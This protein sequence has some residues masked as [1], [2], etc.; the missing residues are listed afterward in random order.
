MTEMNRLLTSAAVFLCLATSATAQRQ[1]TVPTYEDRKEIDLNDFIEIKNQYSWHGAQ[2]MAIHDGYLFALYHLGDCVV[3]DLKNGKFIN[4]YIIAGA[5]KT[6]CN[7]ASFGVEYADSTSRFPLLYVSECG[8]PMR[9]FVIDVS[10]EGSR[11][12]QTV[13][14]VGSSITSYCDWCVDRE[15]RFLYAFGMTPERGVVLKRF[16]LP[17]LADSDADGEVLLGD[18]D[19]L[20]EHTYPKGFF[21]IT[22]GT[23]IRDNYM[24]CPTGYPRAGSC[25]IHVLDLTDG[26][27]A[28]KHNIDRIPY[29]PEGVCTA[30]DRL[31]VF[32]GHNRGEIHSFDIGTAANEK[33][34]Y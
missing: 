26:H 30:G 18:D 1:Y 9:C 3:A 29:E 8:R 21:H 12:I 27:P 4:E 16:R 5:A 11:H 17:S 33:L 6:H 13:R 34:D 2:G 7:N 23:C 10:T 20:W 25:Y 32:F 14:Y 19:I 24:Y 28:D 15:N 22:Q 31:Y